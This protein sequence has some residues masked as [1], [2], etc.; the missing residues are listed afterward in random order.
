[1]TWQEPPRRCAGL[2]E[3]GSG[4]KFQVPLKKHLTFQLLKPAK[5]R[6]ALSL[7]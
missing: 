2:L 1:M 3:G 4:L 5:D 7:P 6:S